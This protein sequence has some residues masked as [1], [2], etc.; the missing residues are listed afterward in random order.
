MALYNTG[1]DL[2]GSGDRFPWKKAIRPD[3]SI[4]KHRLEPKSADRIR[5]N[6]LLLL[7]IVGIVN[8][9]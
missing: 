6:H 1:T 9:G 2:E 7:G 3:T 4:F 5:V 8:L